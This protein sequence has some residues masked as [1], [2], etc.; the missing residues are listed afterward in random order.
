MF[1]LY[2]I[3]AALAGLPAG[4][5]VLSLLFLLACAGLP[6]RRTAPAAPA[7]AA[8]PGRHRPRPRRRTGAG[9]HP[10]QPARPELPARCFRD[11]RRRRQLHRRAPPPSPAPQGVTVLERTD[12]RPSAARATPSTTPSRTCWPA[13]SRPRPSSIV[14]ADTWAAPDFLSRLERPRLPPDTDPRGFGALAGPLR[15][16]ERR[17][18]LAGRPDGR[19]VRPGQPRQA[20]GPRD[21][22]A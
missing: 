8:D 16:P 18:R 9:G 17:R 11:R 10:G 1:L 14:D 12:A 4:L 2:P 6:R 20:A 13:R 22:W 5:S 15:R 7:Y 21:A 19:G 3:V